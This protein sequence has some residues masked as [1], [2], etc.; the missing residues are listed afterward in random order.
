MFGR[1]KKDDAGERTASGL[2]KL[3]PL[4]KAI[5]EAGSMESASDALAAYVDSTPDVAGL[6]A[7]RVEGEGIKVESPHDRLALNMLQAAQ[8]TLLLVPITLM[9]GTLN[10][11]P[12]CKRVGDERNGDACAAC[13]DALALISTAVQGVNTITG[14]FQHRETCKNV[15]GMQDAIDALMM[16]RPQGEA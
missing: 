13:A 2:G 1:K 16:S 7:K 5:K 3:S 10:K 15:R 4:F 8:M 14:Y 9:R 6:V 12:E 11:C